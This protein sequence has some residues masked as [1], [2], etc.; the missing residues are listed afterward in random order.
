MKFLIIDP[1]GLHVDTSRKL[2]FEGHEVYYYCPWH[3]A[4]PEFQNY[5]PGVG[6]SKIN[7][8][9]DYSPYI[10]KVD[11]IVFPDVGMGQ[12]CDWLRNKGYNVFGAGLGEKLEL[13]RKYS[14]EQ[15][16]KYGIKYPKSHFVKG[17]GECLKKLKEIGVPESESK[18]NETNQLTTGK[19]FV[20]FDIWRGNLETFPASSV[21]EANRMFD[22]MKV[23]LGP[24]SDIIPI[25]IQEK[26]EGVESG[27][28]MWF[29]GKEFIPPYMW[30]FESGG[31][32]IGLTTSNIKKQYENEIDKW[33]SLLKAHDY[34]G[35]ISNE[36]IYDGKNF[37]WLDWTP[38]FPMPL[39]MLYT[40]YSD[41]LGDLFYNIAKKQ[42]TTTG[43]PNNEYLGCSMLTSEEGR[44]N[45]VKVTGNKTTR[46]MRTIGTEGGEKYSVPGTSL[47]GII[48]GRGKTI[49][50]LQKD[51]DK[52]AEDVSV[53]F[54]AFN[55]KFID[56]AI[57]KYVNPLKEMG[58]EFSPDYIDTPESYVKKLMNSWK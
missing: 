15:M 57:E 43:L 50:E 26:V 11:C 51:L 13:D 5:A 31:D 45:Y 24:Y 40:V 4:Y 49:E 52:N 41:S 25:T 38:R 9:L 7:K 30:G 14:C 23:K 6:L 34:R 3:S 56:G 44:D 20:K 10:D 58:I 28:D 1:G 12:T 35:A 29:N 32:Y 27:M 46:F 53:Y 22:K 55:T 54:G 17:I 8:V 36:W 2:G 48:P 16:E 42:Y 47:I 19:A 21:T 37:H 33:A 39:G 18:K